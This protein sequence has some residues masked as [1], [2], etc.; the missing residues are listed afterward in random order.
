MS[1]EQK[2][3]QLLASNDQKGFVDMLNEWIAKDGRKMQ[4]LPFLAIKYYLE[5]DYRACANTLRITRD[6]KPEYMIYAV[7]S[8]IFLREYDEAGKVLDNIIP[9]TE[10][11]IMR[12]KLITL[13]HIVDSLSG[14]SENVQIEDALRFIEMINE[15]EENVHIKESIKV[16]IDDIKKSLNISY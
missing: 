13:K 2:C 15:Y 1:Y 11:E 5:R 14:K 8:H 16:L 4:N 9:H 3:R 6:V 7:F 10:D 12:K